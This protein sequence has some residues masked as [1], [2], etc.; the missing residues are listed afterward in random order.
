MPA[1]TVVWGIARTARRCARS[2]CSGAGEPR[3]LAITER[4]R[5][6]RRPARATVDPHELRLDVTLADGTVQHGRPARASPPT[7][8]SPGGRDDRPPRPRRRARRLG[9]RR[10]RRA[11]RR[12]RA[13]AAPSPPS[14]AA[15]A[16]RA[17]DTAADRGAQRRASRCKVADPEGGAA[18]GDPRVYDTTFTLHARARRPGRRAT[19]SAASQGDDVRLDRRPRHV[20]A[21]DARP[22]ENPGDCPSPERARSARRQS[23]RF[24]RG[25]VRARPAARCPGARSPGAA[26]SPTSPG[27]SSTTSRR[28]RSRRPS[29]CTCADGRRRPMITRATIER[30]DGTPRAPRRRSSA[31]ASGASAPS[32]APS[33]VARHRAGPRRRPAVGADRAPRASAAAPASPARAGSSATTSDASTTASASSSATSLEL[34]AQLRAQAAHAR[35]Y[36]LRLDTRSAAPRGRLARAGSSG[37]SST[38]GSS[39]AASCTRTS[40]SVTITTPRDVRTLVPDQGPR[41]H[42]RLRRPVPR[43]EG[44]RHRTP[45]GRPGGDALRCT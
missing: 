20:Q 32:R 28:S 41:V 13:A 34:F 31:A 6:R 4:G 45:Q 33:R 42:R 36:P 1:R 16:P 3:E 19:S 24:T 10:R 18:V 21:H 9:H 17:A 14:Q 38:A 29:S 39:T 7:S 43:R 11:R 40:S 35:R 44:D 37:A 26:P 30:A 23:G 12:A 2:S 15:V 25:H 5:V 8:S 22:L 27:R